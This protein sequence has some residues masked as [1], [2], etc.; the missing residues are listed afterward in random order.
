MLTKNDLRAIK[1]I[2]KGEL[3]FELKPIKKDISTLKTDV[4]SLKI[5]VSTLKTDVKDLKSTVSNIYTFTTS[6]FGELFKWT[7]KIDQTLLSKN[8]PERVDKLEQIIK[9]S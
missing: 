5:G 3:K 8:L 7:D 1:K 2:L 6:A 9:T 4:T